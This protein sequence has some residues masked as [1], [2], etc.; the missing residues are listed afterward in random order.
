MMVYINIYYLIS[1]PPSSPSSLP[2]LSPSLPPSS[3]PSSSPFSSHPSTTSVGVVFLRPRLLSSSSLPHSLTFHP[4]QLQW[5]IVACLFHGCRRLVSYPVACVG[6]RRCLVVGSSYL[7]VALLFF[8]CPLPPHYH[9]LASRHR[10]PSDSTSVARCVPLV[11][12]CSSLLLTLVHSGWLLPLTVPPQHP[13][14]DF[15]RE[16]FGSVISLT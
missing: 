5:M 14:C 7:I 3:S 11:I 1:P 16:I 12:C 8:P 10:L 6:A 15:A 13:V 9:P 4:Q 2:S